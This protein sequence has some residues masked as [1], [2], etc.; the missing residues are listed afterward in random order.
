MSNLENDDDGDEE[1]DVVGELGAGDNIF[2]TSQKNDLF[3]G[4]NSRQ[5]TAS[6]SM[7]DSALF[8]GLEE[9]KKECED[10]FNDLDERLKQAAMQTDKEFDVGRS[11]MKRESFVQKTRQ[12]LKIRKIQ[13]EIEQEK[14]QGIVEEGSMAGLPRLIPLRPRTNMYDQMAKSKIDQ[15]YQNDDQEY[16]EEQQQEIE[17]RKELNLQIAKY[18]NVLDHFESHSQEM[19]EE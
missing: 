5:R 12:A 9:I 14:N 19:S 18:R 16:T 4:L 2:D 13:R 6:A 15:F 3:E 17:E 8:K 11:S 1:A 10:P 7:I